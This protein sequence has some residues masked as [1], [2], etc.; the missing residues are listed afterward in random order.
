[1][2]HRKFFDIAPSPV[3]GIYI[4]PS[5]PT[6]PF[7]SLVLMFIGRYGQDVGLT[8]FHS[9]DFLNLIPLYSLGFV[10]IVILIY[11]CLGTSGKSQDINSVTLQNGA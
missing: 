7:W 8:V 6:E 9:P 11:L 5:L 10:K 3:T 2:K 4:L 1:M